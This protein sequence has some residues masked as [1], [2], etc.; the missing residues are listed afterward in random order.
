MVT[1]TPIGNPDPGCKGFPPLSGLACRF[2]DSSGVY[3]WLSGFINLE[4]GQTHKSFRLD[5]MNILAE[6]AGHPEKCAPSLHVAGSKGKGSVTGMMASILAA[7]GIKTACYASP[8]VSDFRERIM[9]GNKFFEEEIYAGAGNELRVAADAIFSSPKAELF[10]ANFSDGEEPTFFELMTMWFFLC[11][12][13]AGCRAMSVE[14]G[15]GGRLDATNILDP[16]VSVITGIELEHTEYLGNSIEAISK[17]KAGIIKQGRPLVLA[18]QTEE[19]LMVFREFAAGNGSPLFYFPDYA[20]ILDLRISAEGTSFS[21][22]LKKKT[23]TDKKEDIQIYPNLFTPMHGEVMAKNSGLSVLAIKT[24]F[25][26][27]TDESIYSGLAGF[28]LPARFEKISS[29]PNII[30]DGAHTK[31]SMKMCIENFTSFYGKDGILIFGCAAGKDVH[32]MAE[33]SVPCFSV[34]IITAPGT[35]KKS[36][37]EEIFSVFVTEAKRINKR[38]DIIYVPETEEAIDRAVSLALESSLPVLGTGSFYLA[39]EIRKSP[40]SIRGLRF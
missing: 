30:I 11:A 15:M 14:T 9:A 23:N 8:H 25:P 24:A 35:F 31:N 32:S 26:E 6:L 40:L 33:I 5:R 13:L 4:S 21:L 22:K 27:I 34:I 39:A 12:R 28:S 2:T 37:P 36:N 18:E 7:S 17:E 16:L 29:L 19:A 1:S 3:E 10:N 20:E 38:I